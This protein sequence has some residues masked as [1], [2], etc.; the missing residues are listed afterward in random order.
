MKELTIEQ[1]AQRYDE[2]IKKA[3]AK[4]EE[5]KVFDY[6]DEQTA[7]TI[8]LT[9]T[10]IFPELKESE[11][12]RTS[13]EITE[14]LVD[15]NNGEYE[16]PNENTIDSWLSWLEKQG[17]QKPADMDN[18]YL[19]MRET[20]PTNIAEFLDRLTTVEQEF[21]WEHIEKVKKLDREDREQKPAWSEEDDA[22]LDAL[23]RH[24]E[25]EDIHVSPHLAVKCL[26]SLKDRYTWKP[27]DE[28]LEALYRV[29]PEN[30]MEISEDEM[31]L[32]KLYQGLKYG[33]VLSKK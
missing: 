23:I 29:I 33:R 30:V 3:Q 10:D 27:S 28:M 26:K 17:E 2:A 8:R 22:V 19:R 16:R 24:L 1:K 13:R 15:F 9:T 25:G 18:K 6:D 21:L 32:N 20:K 7:H 31:L 14:F 12:E 5:A 11:D 4:I